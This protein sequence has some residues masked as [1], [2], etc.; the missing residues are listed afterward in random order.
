MHLLRVELRCKLP[1]KLHR[2]TG[3]L[4]DLLQSNE[5]DIFLQQVGKIDD[6]L[7][8]C[9]AFCRVVDVCAARKGELTAGTGEIS[10]R[11]WRRLSY[12]SRTGDDKRRELY[13]EITT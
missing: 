7:Q 5:I 4:A 8:V 9:V 3:P 6:L 1:G 2:V 13:T 12:E 10:K 11:P